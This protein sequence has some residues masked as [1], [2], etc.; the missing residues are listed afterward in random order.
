MLEVKYF[1]CFK[2]FITRKCEHFQNFTLFI[3]K[4]AQFFVKWD[5]VYG[6]LANKTGELIRLW[7]V[8]KVNIKQ[9]FVNLENFGTLS[10]M[11]S[12][13]SKQNKV[14]KMEMEKIMMLSKHYQELL[15]YIH[16]S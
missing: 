8:P 9:Y 10:N 14:R 4:I 6:I 1:S 7:K 16:C 12:Y 2:C 13:T 3:R 15:A 5:K 11:C